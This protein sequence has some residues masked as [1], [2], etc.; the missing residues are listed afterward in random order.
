MAVWLA[1]FAWNE[2]VVGSNP[3]TLIGIYL[4]VIGYDVNSKMLYSFESGKN[5]AVITFS[6]QI[7]SNL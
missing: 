2:D 3:A 5:V 4:N 1:Y 7:K 6:L